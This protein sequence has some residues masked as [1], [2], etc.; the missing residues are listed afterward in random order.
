MSY[1]AKVKNGI[2]LEVIRIEQ[3]VLNTGLWG[4]PSEFVQTSYNTH[5]GVH[6]EPNTNPP[7]PSQDQSKALR[8]NYAGI[9]YTYDSV[10]DVFYAPKPYPSWVIGAPSWIWQPPIPYPDDGKSYN[11]DEETQS[12]IE[13]QPT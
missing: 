1:F 7:V 10:N 12:W 6:Y 5:G 8:G 9:G 13:V 4:D 3:D 2:V 11:W